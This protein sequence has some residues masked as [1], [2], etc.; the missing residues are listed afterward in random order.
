MVQN[1]TVT[2]VN[3]VKKY[4][5]Q[6]GSWDIPEKAII[7]G[8][9]ISSW[10]KGIKLRLL[11]GAT[12][13][14]VVRVIKEAG[15]DLGF[16]PLYQKEWF[17]LCQRYLKE[18]GNLKKKDM[19]GVYK[20]GVWYAEFQTGPVKDRNWFEKLEKFHDIWTSDS[21][22]YG[23]PYISNQT[24]WYWAAQQYQLKDLPYY[25]RHAME[26]MKDVPWN[27][28]H[29][30][31]EHIRNKIKEKAVLV[32]ENQL[33][34][35]VDKESMEG[36]ISIEFLGCVPISQRPLEDKDTY[37]LCEV[38]L[39]SMFTEKQY[40]EYVSKMKNQIYKRAKKE[41]IKSRK[42]SKPPILPNNVRLYRMTSNRKR[43][44]LTLIFKVQG[45]YIRGNEN[46]EREE[47][48]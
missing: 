40:L 9:N 32:L 42:M 6:H 10:W 30:I 15:L 3:A 13:D 34:E 17:D 7:D 21:I 31:E 47:D 4:Y 29:L 12:T 5:L 33:Q 25:K 23:I 16:R 44:V 35:I 48:F 27:E 46:E 36:V 2:A 28:P 18:H 43:H 20:I 39:N 14:E 37:F 22:F 19:D 45:N 1:R 8:V 26:S 24:P 41:F 11:E 38:W